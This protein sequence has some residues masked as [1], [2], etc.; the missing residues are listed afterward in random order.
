MALLIVLFI[1]V[2]MISTVAW[3][4]DDILRQ[5]RTT[6]NTRNSS[7]AWQILLGSEAWGISVLIKDSQESQVDHLG[8][9]WN[10]L[11]QGVEIEQGSLQTAI[12]DMQGRLNLNN[13]LDESS[14]IPPQTGKKPDA[15]IWTQAFRRLLI[16]LELNPQLSDAVLDWLDPD[17]DVRSTSGA[18]DL[19]YLSMTPPY[20]AANRAFSDISELLQVKGF[21]KKTV[22][23]LA[24]FIA[25]LPARNIR[26]NINTAP[27]GLLRILGK[28]LL[29]VEES[30]RLVSDRSKANGYTVEEFLQHD[31]M[32]GEQDIAA[33][34]ITNQSRYFLIKSS[35]EIGKT[36]M[37]I[38]SLVERKNG[39]ATVIGRMPVL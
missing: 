13:L 38:N 27:A 33:P 31:M 30:Q 39:L 15:R 11:G 6:E 29:S 19:D 9:A 3:L 18:E 2:I 8:E 14:V 20:R 21:D 16:S 10:N 32:A 26:I 24:P 5:L 36:R 7:Q 1:L 22:Q 25:A 35:T 23:K 28:N 37:K 12:E 34:L 4:S 17:Q